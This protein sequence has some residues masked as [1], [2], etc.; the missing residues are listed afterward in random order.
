MLECVTTSI[1]GYDCSVECR[2]EPKGN[3]GIH[4]EEWIYYVKDGDC[5]T[6]LVVYTRI[7]PPTVTGIPYEPPEGAHL[8]LHCAFDTE[9]EM[10]RTRYRPEVECS[11]V[12]GGYCQQ[13]ADSSTAARD[14]FERFGDPAHLAQPL[15]F[16]EELKAW[17]RKQAARAR[18]E[19]AD[20]QWVRCECCDGRGI[21]RLE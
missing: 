16:W 12:T 3:H 2:H 8:A 21:K 14:F 19:R 11:L 7:Y 6:S 17:H 9:P 4:G 20:L 13:F 15:T 1:P 18:A 10:L 5:A